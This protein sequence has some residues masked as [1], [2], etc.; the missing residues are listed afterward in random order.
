[1][2]Q[3]K[4]YAEILDVPFVFSSNGDGFLFHDRT[5]QSD[6]IEQTLSLDEFPS[7]QELWEKYLKWKDLSNIDEK[8]RELVT[9]PN[10]SDARGKT[11]RY[12][13]QNAINR[14]LDAIAKGQRRLLLVMATGTGKT[15]TAFNIIWRLWKSKQ[16]KRVFPRRP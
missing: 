1:M 9:S 7:K 10:H 12:Y 14:V 2:Q 13:Q 4:D 15:Y 11:P 5:G 16:V 6:P 8:T 3:G